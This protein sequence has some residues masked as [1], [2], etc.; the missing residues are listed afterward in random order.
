MLVP[1]ISKRIDS[2]EEAYAVYIGVLQAVTGFKITE[3]E[4]KVLCVILKNGELTK[5]VRQELTSISTKPRIEN[6]IS[7]LRMKKL[8]VG[9]KPNSKFPVLNFEETTFSITLKPANVPSK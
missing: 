7:K 4:K 9:D 3:Q 2:T 8:I 1:K 6:I 5:D